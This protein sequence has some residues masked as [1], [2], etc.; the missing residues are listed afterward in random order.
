MR[1]TCPPC[2]TENNSSVTMTHVNTNQSSK[3]LSENQ[4]YKKAF[5]W[6]QNLA[7]L[8]CE[9]GMREFNERLTVLQELL[10]SWK[11]NTTVEID[12]TCEYYTG[13]FVFDQ[14]KRKQS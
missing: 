13:N 6:V 1:L 4:K 5:V 2:S 3:Y 8:C 14:W 12:T 9:V 11:A 7:A 10:E